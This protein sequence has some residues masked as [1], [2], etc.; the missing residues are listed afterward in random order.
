MDTDHLTHHLLAMWALGATPSEIQDMWDYNTPYQDDMNPGYPEASSK[1]GLYNP[2]VFQMCLGIDDCYPD[3]LKF[4][5]EEISSKGMQE[6]VKEY[7]FKGD[8][9]ANDILGR[10]FAGESAYP[11]R[12]TIRRS[13]NHS[14]LA[15]ISSIR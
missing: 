15:K 8:E 3:F 11:T 10:M 5:E 1:H 13:L 9:R 2:E 4:F 14:P 6:V 12:T 7:L